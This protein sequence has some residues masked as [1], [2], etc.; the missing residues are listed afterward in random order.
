M[1]RNMNPRKPPITGIAAWLATLTLTAPSRAQSAS[2]KRTLFEL[3]LENAILLRWSVGTEKTTGGA[4]QNRP[5]TCIWDI[6]TTHPRVAGVIT[7]TANEMIMKIGHPLA[8]WGPGNGTW[9][10]DSHGDGVP[11]WQGVVHIM[12]QTGNFITHYSGDGLGANAGL[13]ITMGDHGGV[14]TGEILDPLCSDLR[15]KTRC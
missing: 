1:N 7:I 4:V 14:F 5:V 15:M 6:T 8:G 13:R 9:V 11:A 10:L 12:P 2:C 3:P